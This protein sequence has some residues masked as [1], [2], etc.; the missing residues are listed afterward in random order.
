MLEVYSLDGCYYSQNAEKII[1]E[2]KL[3]ANII[4]VPNDVKIKKEINKKN[5]MNTYPQIFIIF[6]QKNKFKIGGNDELNQHISICKFIKENKF[7]PESVYILYK[8]LYQK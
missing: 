3:K 6:D 8:N 7:V 2:N 1:K 5:K 4:N